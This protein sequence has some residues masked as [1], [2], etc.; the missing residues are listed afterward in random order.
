MSAIGRKRT[1]DNL[2]KGIKKV[3][4]QTGLSFYSEMAKLTTEFIEVEKE[5]IER[6]IQKHQVH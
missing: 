1:F 3:V 6:L 5:Q 2:R 4:G